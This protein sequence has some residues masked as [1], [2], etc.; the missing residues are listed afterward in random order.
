MSKPYKSDSYRHFDE[1]IDFPE[2]SEIWAENSYQSIQSHIV[3]LLTRRINENGI[4]MKE[5]ISS[6]REETCQLK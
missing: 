4:L 2:N 3:N 1:N 6:M 5:N